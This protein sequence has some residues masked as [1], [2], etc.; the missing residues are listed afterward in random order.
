LLKVF[1][2]YTITAFSFLSF[3]L[4]ALW[5][6]KSFELHLI[7][8]R[9]FL[10]LEFCLICIFYNTLFKSTKIKYALISSAIIFIT[11]CIYNYTKS[12]DKEFDFMPLM[13]ECLFFTFFI[14]YYFYDVMQN[15]FK[16]PLFQMPSFWISVAFLIYFSGNFFLFLFSKSM[17]HER[18]FELQYTLIYSTMTIVKNILLCI[19]V[20][21]NNNN[22]LKIDRDTIPVH[23]PFED[24]PTYNQH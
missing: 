19:G 1:F 15:S 3:S 23:L 8:I 4:V 7:L 11:F 12:L 9:L 10:I 16:V 5:Y 14:L 20:I 24:L 17:E 22:T 13:V 6:L 21:V 18:N 2:V